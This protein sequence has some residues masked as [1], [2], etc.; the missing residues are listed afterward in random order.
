MQIHAIAAV[1][2]AIRSQSRL[3]CNRVS[4]TPGRARRPG[5]KS[6]EGIFVVDSAPRS[7]D[8]VPRSCRR[9]TR[10]N[11]ACA[12]TGRLPIRGHPLSAFVSAK[13]SRHA[14]LDDKRGCRDF[15]DESHDEFRVSKRRAAPLEFSNFPAA[16][17]PLF[18]PSSRNRSVINPRATVRSLHVARWC[19]VQF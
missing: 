3:R 10:G 5:Y 16:P 11:L 12:C 14:K 15:H 9:V 18:L 6:R 19:S 17:S 1:L 7:N 8:H 13:R 4:Q 2:A